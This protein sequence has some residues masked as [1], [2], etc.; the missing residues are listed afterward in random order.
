MT[1][2]K[3]QLWQEL[4]RAWLEQR[5]L[6]NDSIIVQGLK[7]YLTSR[8]QIQ[9][10][11]ERYFEKY[12]QE[13]AKYNYDASQEFDGASR[14]FMLDSQTGNIM[15]L[16]GFEQLHED[17]LIYEDSIVK[18]APG[19]SLEVTNIAREKTE[20]PARSITE[21]L[22]DCTKTLE[23]LKSQDGELD[24]DGPDLISLVLGQAFYCKF[25]Y[26]QS[27][28]EYPKELFRGSGH[29]QAFLAELDEQGLIEDGK[30]KSDCIQAMARTYAPYY[31]ELPHR[32]KLSGKACHEIL[33][34]QLGYKCSPQNFRKGF[35]KGLEEKQ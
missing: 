34:L 17:F 11:A 29:F 6:R 32:Q 2:K 26:D 35:N 13:F 19:I 9:K 21:K 30:V 25:L 15:Y 27:G 23:Q 16:V 7:P 18:F 1:E 33:Q 14:C 4:I 12:R 5:R 20:I 28:E 3:R 24:S 8:K 31:K 22:L 10:A